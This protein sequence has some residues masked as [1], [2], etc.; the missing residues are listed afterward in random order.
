MRSN[1]GFSLI[2]LLVVVFI[3]G[4]MATVVSLTVDLGGT[5]SVNEELQQ[6][7]E[8]LLEFSILAEDQAVLSGDPIGLVLIPPGS[9]TTWRYTWQHYRGGAWR[10]LEAPFVIQG[11]SEGVELAIDVEGEE[12]NF[13]PLEEDEVRLPTV[14]FYPGGEVTPFFLTLFDRTEIDV[15]Q[16]LSSQRNGRVEWLDE[17]DL[18]NW[19]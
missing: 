12:V 7:A 14:V 13:E 11:L 16:V 10:D 8:K 17:E 3:I 15:K 5:D 6:Q 19:P 2:E 9:E 4:I 1:S 18:E